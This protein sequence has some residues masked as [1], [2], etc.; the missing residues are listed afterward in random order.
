MPKDVDLTTGP[1]GRKMLVMALPMIGGLM[2]AITFHLADTWF[3][4]RLGKLQLAAMGYGYPLMMFIF[5]FALGIGSGASSTVS[6]ALGRGDRK[7]AAKLCTDSLIFSTGLGVVLAAA[8]YWIYEPIFRVQGADDATV[9]YVHQ[10]MR[11]WLPAVPFLMIT[12]VGNNSLQA[13]GDTRTSGLIL[14]LGSLI[15]IAFDPLLIFGAGPVE[16]MGV[17]GAALASMI[18]RISTAILTLYLLQS[19]HKFLVKSL[20]GWSRFWD[21]TRKILYIGIPSSVTSMLYP[22]SVGVVNRLIST[23]GEAA[24][25]AA[26][27]G[28][29]V[30]SLVMVIYW[31]VARVVNPFAGQNWSEGRGERVNR[32]QRVATLMALGWGAACFGALLIFA[33]HVASLFGKSPQVEQVMVDFLRITS[34]G[35]GFRGVAILGC[36]FFNG[37]NRPLRAGAI[38]VVRMFVL[39]IPM[40]WVGAQ[41]WGLYGVFGGV[42]AANFVGGLFAA[43]W[44]NWACRGDDCADGA[45]ATQEA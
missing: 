18:S 39:T 37:I 7:R 9:V 10:Y 34:F 2:S 4:S 12:M 16:G 44:M 6:R 13:A 31:S 38:D 14:F 40:A 32:V 23:H 22:L 29:R 45:P 15:N 36:A 43:G 35:L 19:R 21:S 26:G 3:V 28:Q 30:E 8:G 24:V 20:P 41:L 42:A 33:P 25:A 17:A 5:S 1:V 27:A 11:Y